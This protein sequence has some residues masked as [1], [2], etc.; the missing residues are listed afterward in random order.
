MIDRV[1]DLRAARRSDSTRKWSRNCAGGG[2]SIPS[3]YRKRFCR[4][5]DFI[6]SFLT[7]PQ[8]TCFD[9]NFDHDL[10]SAARTSVRRRPPSI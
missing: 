4:P 5:K 9:T 6:A 2:R 3:I 8:V 1:A 7:C 10:R